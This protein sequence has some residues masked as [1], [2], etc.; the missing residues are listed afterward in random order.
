MEYLSPRFLISSFWILWTHIPRIQTVEKR[1]ETLA[2]KRTFSEASQIERKCPCSVPLPQ[3][4]QLESY[5]FPPWFQ[6]RG[7]DWQ[8]LQSM[9]KGWIGSVYVCITRGYYIVLSLTDAL[10]AFLH[11]VDAGYHIIASSRSLSSAH[12]KPLLVLP[13]PHNTPVRLVW[14]FFFNLRG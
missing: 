7:Q 1:A 3:Q 6:M 8:A 11:L 10:P 2:T 13:R 12:L 4:T 14:S 5:F 9:P